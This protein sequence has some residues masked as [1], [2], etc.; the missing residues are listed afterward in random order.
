M[1]KIAIL[2]ILLAAPSVVLAQNLLVN[3]GFESAPPCSSGWVSAPGTNNCI[4]DGTTHMP[5]PLNYQGSHHASSDIGTGAASKATI[6]QTVTVV[7]GLTLHLTGAI[8]GATNSGNATWFIRLLDGPSYDPTVSPVLSQFEVIGQYENAWR[9]ANLTGVPTGTQVTVIWGYDKPGSPWTI[10]A[11]HGD[12]F[13]LTQD[14]PTCQGGDPVVTGFTPDFG[15]NDDNQSITVTGTGFAAES[16]VKLRREGFADIE[17]TGEVVTGDT[18]IACTLPLAGVAMGKWSVV[19]TKPN[20]NEGTAPGDFVVANVTINNGSFEDPFAQAACPTPTQQSAPSGWLEIGVSTMAN[21][22][23]RDSDQFVP[24]CPLPDGNQYASIMVPQGTSIGFWSVYQ[25]LAVPPG[26]PLSV[27][28]SFA[29]GQQTTVSLIIREGD[30]EGEELGNTVIEDRSGC[31]GHSYDWVF[32]CVTAPSPTSGLV[33]LDWQLKPHNSAGTP[34]ASHADNL[35]ITTPPAEVCNNG[36]DDDGDRRTDCQDPDCAAEP[37]CT[38][39]P[40]EICN[41]GIDDDGDVRIDCDDSDC[42]SACVE[43]CNNGIDDDFD[44]DVDLDDSECEDCA[45]LVDDNGDGLIDCDDP[46]CLGN[47][48][49]PSETS[50]TNGQDDDGNTLIDCAD[51]S[52][53]AHAHCKANDPFADADGDG[54]VDQADFAAFQLCFTGSGGELIIGCGMFD[55]NFDRVVDQADMNKFEACASGAGIPADPGCDDPAL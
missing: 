38:P 26:Q 40:A 35:R 19:V 45:N 51:P 37:G 16:Q 1:R 27:C 54:D 43:I 7:P 15:A 25:Y 53:A 10:T 41:N 55:P 31:P 32:A 42:D 33:T 17:A 4:W 29:G 44:C 23:V 50:C 12:A 46:T 39:A 6:Y 20:C 36:A 22:L 5:V 18:Q 8:A 52:C 2:V 9:V 13:D 28:G 47:P 48:V 24:S 30:E 3:G 49:C 14:Q 21:H 11:V 34:N